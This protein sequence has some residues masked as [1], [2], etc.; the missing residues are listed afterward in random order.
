LPIDRNQRLLQPLDVERLIDDGH[1]AR[2]IWQVVA[3]ERAGP[4]S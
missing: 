2:Q 3:R 1:A 4:A